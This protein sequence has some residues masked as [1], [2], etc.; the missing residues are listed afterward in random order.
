MIGEVD[1]DTASLDELRA[2]VKQ[3]LE[4]E[5]PLLVERE[6]QISRPLG[7][8]AVSDL[9]VHFDKPECPRCRPFA[10]AWR[11]PVSGAAYA[12]CHDCRGPIPHS[13][14]FQNHGI[15][16]VSVDHLHLHTVEGSGGRQIRVQ[17]K[18][19]LC[20]PC[21]RIDWAKANPLKPCD[22]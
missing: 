16:S 13:I 12:I 6:V 14:E 17:V 2:L 18:R 8:D 9:P 21:F 5:T 4:R 7:V 22:L 1:I 11:E 3:I 20:L 19:E 10:E 15:E